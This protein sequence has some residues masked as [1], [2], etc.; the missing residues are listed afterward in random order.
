MNH[1]HPPPLLVLMRGLPG[2]GKSTVARELGRRLGW[3]V[4]D[5][6]D[7]KDLLDGH[8]TGAGWLSYRVMLNIARSQLALGLSVICDSPLTFASVYAEAE[9]VAAE[10]RARLMVIG[11]ECLD[12][13]LLRARIE[14]RSGSG[15]PSHHQTS[16]AG[17]QAAL[18]GWQEAMAYP[19]AAPLLTLDTARPLAQCVDEAAGWLMELPT[20]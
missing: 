7:V 15:L 5:K 3:P 11:C 16:W 10:W 6:D 4:I 18:P 1:S 14:G 9:Q 13:E 2:S 19:I 20:A 12:N 17:W 8:A